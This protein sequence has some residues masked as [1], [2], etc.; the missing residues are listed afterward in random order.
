MIL[1]C[2]DVICLPY[3]LFELLRFHMS[4]IY[5]ISR[6]Q[7]FCHPVLWLLPVGRGMQYSHCPDLG[8][9]LDIGGVWSGLECALHNANSNSQKDLI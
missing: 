3:R 2:Y 6:T 8:H 4:T 1:S 7:A 9:A 5:T